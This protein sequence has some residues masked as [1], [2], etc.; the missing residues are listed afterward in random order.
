MEIQKYALSFYPNSV[1]GIH[2]QRVEKPHRAKSP[3]THMYYQIYYIAKGTLTHYIGGEEVLLG[4]GD[5][6]ILPPG[7]V[8]RIEDH[9]GLCFYSLSFME[10]AVSE[11]L[12]TTEWAA[13]FLHS[14][15]GEPAIRTSPL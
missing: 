2:I 5:M 11:I 13:A 9:D 4:A 10:E 8:H 7:A 3:H 12:Q 1:D 14:L 15:R 6:F